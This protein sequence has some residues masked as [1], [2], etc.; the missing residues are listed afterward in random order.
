MQ[1]PSLEFTQFF[2]PTSPEPT[3]PKPT[4]WGQLPLDAQERTQSRRRFWWVERDY[5]LVLA[6]PRGTIL[7]PGDRLQAITGEVVE[8]IA[9]A[10]R[11]LTVRSDDPQQLLRAAY[12]LGNRHVPLEITPEYLR[13][14]DDPVLASL[15]EQL[16]IQVQPET[17]P[18][19][20]EAG[21]YHHHH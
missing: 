9:K 19:L 16:G 14:E 18:F 3:S 7:R 4:V 2:T 21:A 1:S 8:I 12:H 15:L 6:L 10:Q 13:L 11:V 5:E 20:P 17:A